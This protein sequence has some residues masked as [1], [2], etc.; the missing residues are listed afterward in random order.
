VPRAKYTR[1]PGPLLAIAQI[2]RSKFQFS[3]EQ[4]SKLAKL[5]PSKL[6]N[7]GVPPPDVQR[8]P[9]WFWLDFKLADPGVPPDAAG[10]LPEKAKTITDLVIEITE[11][12]INSH[13]TATPLISDIPMNPANVRAAICKLLKAL[14]PFIKGWVDSETADIVPAGL[15]AKLAARELKLRLPAARQRALAMLCRFI[16]VCVRQFAA[17]NNESVNQQNMLRYVDTALK[18]AGIKHPNIAKHRDRLAKLTFPSE[19]PPH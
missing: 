12:A 18:F 11:D 4:R 16:E 8:T 19:Q 10:T 5:L 14:E 3:T 7:L 15:D 17:A 9:L 1:P 13:L 2:Q 6:A